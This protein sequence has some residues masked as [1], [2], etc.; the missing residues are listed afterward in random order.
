M[1][2]AGL[3][4]RLHRYCPTAI[5][6]DDAAQF[7]PPPGRELVITT[8]VLV[9]GVHFRS[10]PLSPMNCQT[11]TAADVGWRAVA[12][13]YSDLAAM[14]AQPLGI[15]V[16]LGLPPD[17]P[18]QW[19][20]QMY[21]G[22]AEL[23][24][25]YGGVIWGGDVVRSGVVFVSITAV[26]Y[27]DNLIIKRS[28]AQVG[29]WVL[30]TGDHGLSRAG[31]A[32]LTGETDR[33]IPALISAHRRPRPRL[34]VLPVLQSLGI[35]RVAGMD[36]SDGLADALWQ[37]CRASGVGAV[38]AQD[39]AIHPLLTSQFPQQAQEWLWYGGEDF[40]LVLTLAPDYA[41]KL[42]QKLGHPAQII[43]KIVAGDQV[44]WGEKSLPLTGG[45][46]H[47]DPLA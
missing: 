13:N 44:F 35:D 24:Q 10:S 21:E 4:N 3:L 45:F 28:L 14:G 40:E 7:T 16:G 5:I 32:L 36:S 20:E 25:T 15:T 34:D 29:D 12:V 22:M 18:V 17:V 30:V 6:G 11:M 39:I 19:V 26:G 46:Q 37:I 2:E 23:L 41:Q 9:E 38:L 27:I 1:G 8:D 43:G 42:V 47:F 31:L 33:E